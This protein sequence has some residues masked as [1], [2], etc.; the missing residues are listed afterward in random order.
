MYRSLTHVIILIEISVGQDGLGQP[1]WMRIPPSMMGEK[2]GNH[3]KFIFC[4]WYGFFFNLILYLQVYFGSPELKTQMS[5]SD[6]CS[7]SVCSSVCML[8]FYIFNFFPRTAGP[9]S[10]KVGTINSSLDKGGSELYMYKW[11]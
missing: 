2:M 10:T 11:R 4:K 6:R 8:D 7:L 1:L 5:F 3:K 9:N